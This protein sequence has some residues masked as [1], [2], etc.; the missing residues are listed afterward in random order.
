[1]WGVPALELAPAHA[2]VPALR[3]DDAIEGADVE[4]AD[5]DGGLS[6]S[7]GLLA[8]PVVLAAMV[9]CLKCS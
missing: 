9:A 4:G 6:L 1:M 8:E 2:G 7:G 5:V 3:V